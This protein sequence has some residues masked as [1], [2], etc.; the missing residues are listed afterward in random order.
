MSDIITRWK[1]NK[2]PWIYIADDMKQWAL[3]HRDYFIRLGLQNGAF[4]EKAYEFKNG[5]VYRLCSDYTEETDIIELPIF[6]SDGYL[7]FIK[8][9]FVQALYLLAP[10]CVII[11]K[12]SVKF[13]GF[14]YK[15]GVVSTQ[16]ILCPKQDTLTGSMD[17]TYPVSVLFKKV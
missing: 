5:F 12:E 17:I 3:E 11:N 8:S 1:E 7:R 4:T 14:K 15:T 10:A 9:E 6:E 2:Y 13:A 16:P